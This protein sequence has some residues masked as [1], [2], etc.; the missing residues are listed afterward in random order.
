MNLPSQLSPA[1]LQ[2]AH[3]SW[4]AFNP[5]YE[6]K[7]WSHQ[8]CLDY[9]KKVDQT[10]Y[11][12]FLALKPYSYKCDFFRFCIVYLEGGYYSDWKQQC[13]YS[14]DSLNEND[15]EWIS[16]LDTG[17]DYSTYYKCMGTGFFG[18]KKNHPILKKTIDRIIENT[19]NK[20]YGNSCLDPTGPFLFGIIFDENKNEIK[21]NYI[22]GNFDWNNYFTM[23][24][25]KVVQHKCDGVSKDSSWENGNNYV[26]MWAFREVYY[27]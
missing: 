21:G 7:Y 12:T 18:A 13:L 15:N 9:L 6:I 27:C 4:K 8:D 20:Y 10:Y 11:E 5:T 24:N 25:I 1:T 14:L 16:C 2:T 17:T 23:N 26:A 19:K 3:D 22:M